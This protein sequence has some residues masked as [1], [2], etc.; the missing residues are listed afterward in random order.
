MN[1]LAKLQSKIIEKGSVLSSST[2][3]KRQQS[4]EM[5]M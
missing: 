1:Y 5:G 3:E 2:L 4:G